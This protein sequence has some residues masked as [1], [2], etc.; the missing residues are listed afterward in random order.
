[1][2]SEQPSEQSNNPDGTDSGQ[3]RFPAPAR[4]IGSERGLE[5]APADPTD[6]RGQG[7]WTTRYPNSTARRKQLWEGAYL[8]FLYLAAGPVLLFLVWSGHLAEW[9]A[10]DDD[11][12]EAFR[13]YGLAWLAG[14][15][16]GT[17]FT[18]KWLYHSVAHGFWHEDRL[19]WRLFTP[20]L[21]AAF[22]F[23]LFALVTSGLIDLIDAPAVRS[24]AATVGIAFLFGYFS[25]F[26]VARLAKTARQLLGTAERPSITAAAAD[27]PADVAEGT[28]A[29][30]DVDPRRA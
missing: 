2:S 25:D 14:L 19:L 10:V 5:F 26:T 22:A 1:M 21:S 11:L 13:T 20:H 27:A 8:G 3:D 23:G 6:G 15:L 12:K 16:G 18:T 17:V 4:D 29:D 28:T 24:P 30:S 7:Q 9:L